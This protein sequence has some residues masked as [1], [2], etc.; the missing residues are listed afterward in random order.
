[1]LSNPDRLG[2]L[3]S[4]LPGLANLGCRNT[5]NRAMMEKLLGIHRD[6]KLPE[7]ADQT[8]EKWH[9]CEDLPNPPSNPTAK[10]VLFPTCFINYYDTAPG[11]AAVKVFAKNGCEI[12]CPKQNCC[13]MPAVDGGDIAVR[14]EA[15]A[16]QCGFD[17]ALGSGAAIKSRRSIRPAR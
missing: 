4:L 3:G 13:G 7:F 12:A 9:R 10:V 5:L 2:K 16:L 15:G 11:K 14:A 8:L 17:A 6:K 1:M